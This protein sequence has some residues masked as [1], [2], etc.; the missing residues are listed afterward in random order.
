MPAEPL[1]SILVPHYNARH[2]LPCMLDSILPQSLKSLE[3]VVVDDGSREPCRE[4]IDSYRGKGL[5]VRLI[6]HC[7]N[8]GTKE[9]RLT[10]V[11]HA[12]GRI[13]AFADADDL[14][15]GI[16]ILEQHVRLLLRE[17]ADILHYNVISR[18]SDGRDGFSSRHRPYATLLNGK[19]VFETYANNHCRG[20]THWNKLYSANL[21][22]ACLPAARSL[23]VRGAAEDFFLV[24]LLF[25]QAQR[26]R[27]S[28]LPGYR[29]FRTSIDTNCSRA[30]G[31]LRE[32]HAIANWFNVWLREKHFSPA[33]IKTFMMTNGRVMLGHAAL[34]EQACHLP[35]RDG[36]DQDT[37]RALVKE[38]DA[39]ALYHALEFALEQSGQRRPDALRLRQA[40]SELLQTGGNDV[41]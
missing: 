38:M 40:F 18:E 31:Y 2:V 35:E 17:E 27:G 33:S 34:L 4:V 22:R 24:S 26:Y 13:I 6:E 20:H 8:K 14:F 32:K 7:V 9:A 12:R 16:D 41:S 39:T 30:A 28:E 3:V 25:S 11:E 21:C 5:N 15:L 23:S 10:G 19:E 37:F 36:F 29:Y 1:L